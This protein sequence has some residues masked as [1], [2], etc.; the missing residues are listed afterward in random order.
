[1]I[2]IQMNYIQIN[3]GKIVQIIQMIEIQMIAINH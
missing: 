1:M 2:Y 3:S